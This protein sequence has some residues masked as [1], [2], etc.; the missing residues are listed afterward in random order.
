V[1]NATQGDYFL[2]T[3]ND[4]INQADPS[5]EFSLFFPSRA[6]CYTVAFL[7]LV[8]NNGETYEKIAEE[9]FDDSVTVV[10]EGI[11]DGIQIDEEL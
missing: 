4:P 2:F 10:Y 7:C 1:G 6:T 8:T 5:G 9:A 3:G 11:E